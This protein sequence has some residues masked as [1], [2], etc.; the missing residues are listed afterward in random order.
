MLRAAA[1]VAWSCAMDL[2]NVVDTQ[3]GFAGMEPAPVLTPPP[4]VLLN[5]C[6]RS[7]ERPQ[8]LSGAELKPLEVFLDVGQ[9]LLRVSVPLLPLP[10]TWTLTFNGARRRGD[11]DAVRWFQTLLHFI[12]LLIGAGSLQ[13][14]FLW[15]ILRVW[16]PLHLRKSGHLETS[17]YIDEGTL[18]KIC[19][20][21][22]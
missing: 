4:V 20:G 2:F 10:P 12:C 21:A 8:H 11:V 19:T 6:G 15:R 3:L 5:E 18:L 22:P 16:I 1:Q 13:V 9:R 14:C 17:C 7:V